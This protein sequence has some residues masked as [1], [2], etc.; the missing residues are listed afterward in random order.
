MPAIA[1]H[2]EPWL[3]GDTQRE[4]RVVKARDPLQSRSFEVSLS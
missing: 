4:K 3:G 1:E 2:F